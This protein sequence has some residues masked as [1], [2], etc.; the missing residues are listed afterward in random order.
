MLVLF[1]IAFLAI[2]GLVAWIVPLISVQ[3]ASLARQ[4]PA[5]TERTRDR[6]VD[7]IYRYEHTFGVNSQRRKSGRGHRPR[8][9]AAGGADAR[10]V[11]ADTHAAVPNATP[12]SGER[13]SDSAR[14]DE[15]HFRRSPAHS[16]LGAETVAGARA[17][18]YPILRRSFGC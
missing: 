16:G 12:V 9:L 2:A 14:A 18:N 3:S 11:S 8:E 6:V 17:N 1:A 7:L 13:R 5:F 4:L 10:R 15:T